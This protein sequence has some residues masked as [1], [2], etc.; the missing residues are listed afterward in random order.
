MLERDQLQTLIDALVQRRDA[1][2]AALE[3]FCL[4]ETFVFATP[5]AP[6]RRLVT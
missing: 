1:K 4:R 5:L 6:T 2:P 3:E